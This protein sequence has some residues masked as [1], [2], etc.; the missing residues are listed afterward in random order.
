MSEFFWPVIAA[1]LIAF[2]LKFAGFLVP[3]AILENDLF[4]KIIPVLPIG[5]LSGLI[6]V[7]VL[8]VKQNIVFDGRLVGV[9]VGVIALFFRAPFIVVV[10]LAAF[11]TALGRANGLWI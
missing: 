9:G 10:L 8:A 11:V 5:M 7:Q 2:G 4:R 6:A 3:K 1:S